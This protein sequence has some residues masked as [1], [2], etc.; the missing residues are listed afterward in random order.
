MFAEPR[1]QNSFCL[2]IYLKLKWNANSPAQPSPT[3][4]S[5]AQPR[6]STKTAD[7]ISYNN[8]NYECLPLSNKYVKFSI[9]SILVDLQG[10]LN[11]FPDFFFIWAL[12]LIVY[13]W[14]SSPHQSNLFDCNAL[15]V[16]F[17]KLLEGLMEVLL[18]ENVNDLRHILFHHLN[19][20]MTTA[21]EL[22]E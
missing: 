5:P 13:T 7:S 4:P 21:S 6:I 20:L 3:Q 15:I 18:C 1:L 19:F 22:R 11:K 8:Y 12:L 2:T 14:N 17:Q 10:S 9:I 16:P